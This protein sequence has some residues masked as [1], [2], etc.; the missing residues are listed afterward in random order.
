MDLI[1]KIFE[2]CKPSDYTLV[3]GDMF[4]IN[5][6]SI[7]NDFPMIVLETDYSIDFTKTAL[8]YQKSFTFVFGI[9]LKSNLDDIDVDREDYLV[10]A[11]NTLDTILLNL[12]RLNYDSTSQTFSIQRRT[13]SFAVISQIT[14]AK[15]LRVKNKFS[16]NTDG[17]LVNS[18]TIALTDTFNS[19]LSKN[20]LW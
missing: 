16:E 6:L 20:L 9:L 7:N 14:Q 18:F 4:E 19:C 1:K 3:C 13:Q 17:L 15:A 10:E 11:I 8:H 12:E 5:T 2:I